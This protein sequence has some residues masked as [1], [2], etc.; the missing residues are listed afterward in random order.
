MADALKTRRGSKDKYINTMQMTDV[1]SQTSTYSIPSSNLRVTMVSGSG[2]GNISDNSE[3]TIIELSDLV[4]GNEVN[5]NIGEGGMIVKSG[6]TTSFGQ[7]G[8]VLG[9]KGDSKTDIGGKDGIIIV[10][11]NE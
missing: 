3:T 10:N 2:G 5:V 9:G 4:I 7:Y 6:G 1:I 11:Y 8:M